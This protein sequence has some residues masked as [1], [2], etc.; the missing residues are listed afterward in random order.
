MW[1]FFPILYLIT[2]TTLWYQPKLVTDVVPNLTM[3]TNKVSPSTTFAKLP[4]DPATIIKLYKISLDE[5]PDKLNQASK[6][7]EYTFKSDQE[8]IDVIAELEKTTETSNNGLIGKFW[9]MVTLVNLIWLVSSVV[10]VV[11]FGPVLF[12]IFGPLIIHLAQLLY[13]IGVLLYK[14]RE[15]LGYSFLTLMLIQSYHLHKDIGLYI[16]FTS[17]IGFFAQW[18]YSLSIHTAK[19]G[20]E[21][22][23]L[24]VFS[25]MLYPTM[26]LTLSYQSQL[27]GFMSVVLLYA[28]LGFS[29]IATG[30]TYYVG[31]KDKTSL[32]QC[33]GAS[34]IMLP[35]YMMFV[36]TKTELKYF[37]Y[38]FYVFGFVAYFLGLLIKSSAYNSK[39]DYGLTQ[40]ITLVSLGASLYTSTLL[41][42][43]ALYNV[44]LTFSFLCG[45]EKFVELDV[46]KNNGVV[47]IFFVA[48][49]FYCLS[50]WLN[51]HP[52]FLMDTIRG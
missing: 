22:G 1:Y 3:T 20:T 6:L 7:L 10:I 45:L 47:M 39:E 43:G 12:Q 48:C 24:V 23:K 34:L 41:N 36:T 8:L 38:G 40:I 19:N 21:L 18:M 9:R 42:V 49:I 33:I 44:T 37:H 25:T 27:L 17:V 30:L 46:W 51:T 16:A 2:I 5:S 15:E 31:F 26:L 28:Y 35:L 11:L 14:I 50:F 52:T 13:E 4:R 29:A 32:N